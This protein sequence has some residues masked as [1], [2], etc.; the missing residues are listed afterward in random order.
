MT[1]GEGVEF[2]T[3]VYAGGALLLLLVMV[4]EGPGVEGVKD[5][6]GGDG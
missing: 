6:F 4:V 2:P 1:C 3:G 5:D